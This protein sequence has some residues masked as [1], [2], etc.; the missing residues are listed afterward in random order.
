ML[1]VL[2]MAMTRAAPET[3]T[4]VLQFKRFNMAV[5]IQGFWLARYN[6]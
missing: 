5:S 3:A 6:F 1:I 2:A 4:M